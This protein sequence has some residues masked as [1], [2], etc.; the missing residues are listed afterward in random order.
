[1]L[2]RGDTRGLYIYIPSGIVKIGCLYFLYKLFTYNNFI[3][4]I[5]ADKPD[6]RGQVE[7]SQEGLRISLTASW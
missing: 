7:T 4:E 3:L 6:W 1:M 2:A 5:D